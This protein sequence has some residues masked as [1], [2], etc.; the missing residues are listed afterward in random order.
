VFLQMEARTEREVQSLATSATGVDRLIADL[1][2]A[3][4]VCERARRRA[5]AELSADELFVAAPGS[6]RLSVRPAPLSRCSTRNS[7]AGSPMIDQELRTA[8]FALASKGGPVSEDSRRQPL[9]LLARS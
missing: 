2:A 9:E 5:S 4:G 7:A 6:A 8:I 1:G 3:A